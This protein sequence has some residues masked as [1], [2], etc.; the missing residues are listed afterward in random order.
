[1]MGGSE[2]P[3]LE[4]GASFRV[5]QPSAAT[6]RSST[7]LAAGVM[8]TLLLL[9]SGVA[10]SVV[11]PASASAGETDLVAGGALGA[12]PRVPESFHAKL[13]MELPYAGLVEP[14]EVWS[15]AVAG[16]Q[17]VRYWDGL[18]V[19]HLNAGGPGCEMVPVSYDGVT[20]VESYIGL[21]P[22]PLQEWFPDTRLFTVATR[23]EAVRGVECAVWALEEPNAYVDHGHFVGTY[24]LFTDRA[25]GTPVRFSFLGHNTFGVGS[26]YDNY[27]WEYYEVTEGAPDA[28]VF[29]LPGECE[30]AK[31]LESDDAPAE[32]DAAAA[33]PGPRAS[34]TGFGDH[35]H[36]AL[37]LPGD[38]TA[39][40]RRN[41]FHAWADAHGRDDAARTPD[42]LAEF[43]RV[44]RAVD[45]QNRRLRSQNVTLR[46]NEMADWTDEERRRGR[47]GFRNPL[48]EAPSSSKAA[49]SRAADSLDGYEFGV[50]WRW[51]ER[52]A[53]RLAPTVD[54]RR[55]GGV[56]PVK[57]QGTCGSCW[58]FGTVAALEGALFVASGDQM[59][60]SEQALVDCSWPEG[61]N[62]CDGGEDTMAYEWML[63]HQGVPST[64][65]YGPYLNADG[66][67]HVLDANPKQL[68]ALE[69]RS[70]TRVNAS[71]DEVKDALATRGTLVVRVQATP[72]SFYFYGGGL[73]DVPHDECS[74]DAADSD[75]IVALVGYGYEPSGLGYWILR[76][77]WSSHW[78]E[79]GYMRIGM[80]NVCGVTNT[81][82]YPT[83]EKVFVP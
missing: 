54:W 34:Y 23:V 83:V 44:K 43:H 27:T 76:N 51:H 2:G 70:W 69:I 82:T 12:A 60:L 24:E 73:Y 81:P 50:F 1:M 64:A 77:S 47:L 19:F 72:M 36:A 80:D 62:G 55:E 75:H 39:G 14:V 17:K 53:K 30:G 33:A 32:D 8:A 41:A 49:V 58:A 74:R 66:L 6:P 48:K 3:I 79:D 57:D 21:P 16:L 45:S 15:D 38:T 26:H 20:G 63:H 40:L 59:T 35:H 29:A 31:M 10:L 71:V 65:E 25:T 28:S 46:L 78:G 37:M 9:M 18:N 13:A 5:G 52:S 11:G 22:W 67:C 4:R 68:P 56:A 61:N 7:A 42:R